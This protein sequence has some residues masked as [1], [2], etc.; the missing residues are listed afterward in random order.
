MTALSG[1]AMAFFAGDE[2]VDCALTTPQKAEVVSKVDINNVLS[3][4]FILKLRVFLKKLTWLQ[5]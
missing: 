1:V 5:K 2:V 3:V 4:F